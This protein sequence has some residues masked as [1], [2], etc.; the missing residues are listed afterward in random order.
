[1]DCL[2]GAGILELDAATPGTYP[3][4]DSLGAT[5]PVLI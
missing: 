4:D 3:R 5:A 1:M 2:D